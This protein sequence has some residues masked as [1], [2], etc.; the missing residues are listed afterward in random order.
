MN[1]QNKE[2]LLKVA[3]QQQQPTCQRTPRGFSTEILEVRGLRKMYFKFQKTTTRNA[4][5]STQGNDLSRFK[6]N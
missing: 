5:R 1:T 4:D 3:K 2:K 6:D